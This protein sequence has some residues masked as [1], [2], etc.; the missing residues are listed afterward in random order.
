MSSDRYQKL[1]RQ[2][3]RL[4]ETLDE[5]RSPLV[6]EV[7]RLQGWFQ[8]EILGTD[9][10]DLDSRSQSYTTEI[11]KQLRLLATDAAFL[12]SAR[13]E[14]TQAQRRAQIRDR[15]STMRR[16]CNVILGKDE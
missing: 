14:T 11:H 6:P 4:C 2:I 8:T 10:A 15:L 9:F 16:Y 7:T 3:D 5:A 13:Q 12:Q 1:V